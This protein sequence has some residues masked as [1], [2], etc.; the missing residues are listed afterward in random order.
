MYRQSSGISS[1]GTFKTVQNAA[2]PGVKMQLCWRISSSLKPP[3]PL[4][5]VGPPY[6]L[7]NRLDADAKGASEFSFCAVGGGGRGGEEPRRSSSLVWCALASKQ[8]RA[9]LL[10]GVQ[11]RWPPLCPLRSLPVADTTPASYKPVRCCYTTRP[12][13]TNRFGTKKKE[14][15]D[16]IFQTGLGL[17]NP[18]LKLVKARWSLMSTRTSTSYK[19]NL[20]LCTS[21]S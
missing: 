11:M 10:R 15:T 2:Y 6:P 5:K 8:L 3:F 17:N 20:R 18:V 16:Q 19:T 13:T 7:R 1:V 4:L 14:P 12:E 9:V 21:P